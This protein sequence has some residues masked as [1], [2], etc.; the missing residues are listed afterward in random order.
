M[1]DDTGQERT[2]TAPRL[3]PGSLRALA[4]PMR[5]QILSVLNVEGPATSA[6]LARRL[7]IRTGSTSWHLSKLAE[8]SLIEEIPERGTRRERWWR[9]VAPTWSVDAAHYLDDPDIKGEAETLLASV[10][11]EQFRRAHQFLTEEWDAAWRRAWILESAPP[12]RLDPAGLEALREELDAVL[13]RYMKRP[14]DGADAE[15]VLVQLQG[16]PI[17]EPEQPDTKETRP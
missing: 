9:A 12:L 4:H 15:T 11:S 10:I 16:F 1:D 17:Q 14:A 2:E 13:A 7:R 5:V 3:D 6:T 8:Q